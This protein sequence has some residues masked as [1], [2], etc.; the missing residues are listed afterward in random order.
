MHFYILLYFHLYHRCI[1][2]WSGKSSKLVEIPRHLSF[3]NNFCCFCYFVL[4]HFVNFYKCFVLPMH[5]FPIC[6]AIV[7]LPFLSW[8]VWGGAHT[9]KL[10]PS[11][12]L[13]DGT[14]Y[15]LAYNLFCSV[16][17]LT[18]Y[19]SNSYCLHQYW[20]HMG[21]HPSCSILT[22]PSPLPLFSPLLSFYP[23]PYIFFMILIHLTSTTWFFSVKFYIFHF[24][25]Y[26]LFLFIKWYDTFNTVLL[27]ASWYVICHCLKL[28]KFHSIKF[29]VNQTSS[30]DSKS[31][32]SLGLYA[33][34][35]QSNLCSS[36]SSGF[37][38]KYIT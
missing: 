7:H 25:I 38:K 37:P 15:W 5:I 30:P 17:P 27:L 32:C 10:F 18:F 31:H 20:F 19:H 24:V 6:T 12:N 29:V 28:V 13:D 16:R 21:L 9:P 3:F 8:W 1:S 22:K 23:F 35:V 4:I 36:F 34:S 26:W 2:W 11:I 14:F 33:Y